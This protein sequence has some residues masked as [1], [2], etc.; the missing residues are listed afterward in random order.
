MQVQ[1]SVVLNGKGNQGN[2][3]LECNKIKA[4]I[5]I[6][7]LDEFSWRQSS[8][9]WHVFTLI[10]IT[11]EVKSKVGVIT[12][13]VSKEGWPPI[14]FSTAR[15]DFTHFNFNCWVG[16]SFSSTFSVASPFYGAKSRD[17]TF[18]HGRLG[19]LS[20]FKI[21]NV[22][23]IRLLWLLINESKWERHTRFP[24]QRFPIYE[25]EKLG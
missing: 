1:F 11:W 23:G 24:Y 20:A 22:E 5:L 14:Y 18:F 3:K 4:L 19:F 8:T 10:F 16:L 15:D 13:K 2:H 12:K 17:E 21:T 9:V 6:V 7:V 25:R